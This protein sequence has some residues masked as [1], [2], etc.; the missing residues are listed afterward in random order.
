MRLVTYTR[1]GVPSIGLEID[2]GILDIPEAASRF[3]R[4]YHIH[5]A[6]FPNTMIDL[7][8]WESGI[9][10]VSKIFAA[11]INTPDCERPMTYYKSKIELKAPI[12]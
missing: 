8:K 12:A 7:L 10:V 4:T 3:G 1:L 11:L 9:E 6:S 2:S 5:G